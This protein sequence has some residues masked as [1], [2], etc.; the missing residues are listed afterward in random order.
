MSNQIEI[1]GL[2]E[3]M[4]KLEYHFAN[5]NELRDLNTEH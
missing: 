5:P 2:G 1:N 4:T 3:G